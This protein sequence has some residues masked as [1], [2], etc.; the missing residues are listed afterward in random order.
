MERPSVSELIN[1]KK[2]IIPF[3]ASWFVFVII[4]T[5]IGI[6]IIFGGLLGLMAFIE[7]IP[8]DYAKASGWDCDQATFETEYIE[9]Y[10]EKIEELENK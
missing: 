9:K 3:I 10:M 8:S 1:S 6:C 2:F 5:I 7:G 4:F